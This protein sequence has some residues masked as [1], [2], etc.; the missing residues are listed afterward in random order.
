MLTCA[1]FTRQGLLLCLLVEGRAR[2]PW[3]TRGELDPCVSVSLGSYLGL[4]HEREVPQL[5]LSLVEG[6]ELQQMP[7][8]WRHRTLPALGNVYQSG[9]VDAASRAAGSAWS[10]LSAG[11]GAGV[12]PAERRAAE[13]VSP[14]APRPAASLQDRNWRPR[15]VCWPG[16]AALVLCQLNHGAG[17]VCAAAWG[18]PVRAKH[19]PGRA[20]VHGEILPRALCRDR[21]GENTW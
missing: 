14:A 8:R 20:R 13:R 16:A 5:T 15:R 7:G 19:K 21:Y 18:C 1:H 6:A 11:T 2:E 3:T 10:I 12:A 4:M 17:S 9:P